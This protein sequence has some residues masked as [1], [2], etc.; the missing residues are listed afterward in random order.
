[1][2]KL[3]TSLSY[4]T[5]FVISAVISVYLVWNYTPL[6]ED[7]RTTLILKLRPYL[8]EDFLLHDFSLGLGYI[9]FH[10][11]TTSNERHT[12]QV[13]LEEIRFNYDVIQLIRHNFEPLKVLKSVTL[14][15]P[16]LVLYQSGD[17]KISVKQDGLSTDQMVQKIL[18]N[19]QKIPSIDRVLVN[20]AQVHWELRNGKQ[21]PVF[22]EMNG[23]LIHMNEGN[24]RL[25][26]VGK[27]YGSSSSS[28]T[29]DGIVD[30]SNESIEAD[31]S[32]EECS[33][34]SEFPFLRNG[35]YNFENG[36]LNGQLGLH[37]NGFY[38]DSL[39]IFGQVHVKNLSAF[40]FNQHAIAGDC[41]V[42]FESRNITFS[43]FAGK[44]EEGE[45]EFEGTLEN[46][47]NPRVHWLV[48]VNNFPVKYLKQSHN[49]FEYA[50]GGILTGHGEFHGPLD[51]IRVVASVSS[52]EIMY[53]VV[54]FKNLEAGLS[55]HK[56]VLHFS[57]IRADFKKFSTEGS[58]EV[59][60]KTDNLKFL[61]KS[62]LDVPAETF[63]VVDKLNSTKI[64]INSHLAGPFLTKRFYGTFDYFFRKGDS[65]L[66][67]GRGPFT[68]DDQ[69]LNFM[70][71][72]TNLPDPV[73]ISGS[74][75][76]IFSNPTVKILKANDL[77]IVEFTSNRVVANLAKK[78]IVN[79]VMKGPYD[80]LFGSVTVQNLNG[81]NNLFS[82]SGNIKE[83]F[84]DIQNFKG[85]FSALTAP[86]T[87]NGDIELSE[88][89]L[90]LDVK[91]NS[92][93]LATGNLF[94]GY[95][96][97][98]PIKGKLNFNRFSVSD[99]V[100][101]TEEISRSL[102]QGYM[103]G[104]L[105]ISGTIPQPTVDFYLSAD[106][107][108]INNVG[109]YST[110][111]SGKLKE[112]KL[113]FENF[114]VQLNNSPVFNAN[115]W[116]D[117]RADSLY[118]TIDGDNIESNFIAE[119]IFKD[120]DVIRGHFS[121]SL[122][123]SGPS[124]RPVISG[125]MEIRDGMLDKNSFEILSAAFQDSIPPETNLTD[126]DEHIIKI[127]NFVYVDKKNYSVSAEGLVGIGENSALDL[128]INLDGNILAELPRIQP[129]F[130]NPQSSG[131]LTLRVQGS[132][133][134]PIISYADLNVY[135]GSLEFESVLPPLRN[136]KADIELSEDGKYVHI[137]GIE[138][139]LDNRW[140]KIYNLERVNV[141]S[142]QLNS[143][144][145]EDQ[146]LDF[147]TLV[148]E[149][150]ERGIPLSIP[151]LMEEGDIGYFAVDGRQKGE[152][153]YFSGPVD[154]PFARGKV[155]LYNCRVTFPFIGMDEESGEYN[156]VVEFLMNIDWDVLALSGSGNRYFVEIPAYVGEAYLDL[157]ID[158]LSDGL[159][160]SGKL[161]DES[162]RV[163]GSVES[164]RGR[165]EYLDVNFRVEKFGTEFSRFE[166]YPTVYGRAYTTVRDS[167]GGFPRDIYLTLYA[168]D[169][170][171]NQEISR[172]R[173]EDFRFKLVSSD[174]VEGE[175][176]EQ[177]LAYLGY[178][179]QN[180]PGKASEVGL[181]MTENF[182]IRPFFRPLE[183]QIER[184]LRLDY[185][186]LRS[187]V[188][189]NLFYMSTQQQYNSLN[190]PY[191]INYNVNSNMNPA[192]LLFQ[193]A[194]ITLGKYLA[195]DLYFTYTG[196]LLSGYEEANIDNAR[197]GLYHR[198]GLEY[199]LL[200][201]LLLEVEYDNFQLNTYYYDKSYLN[202]FRIR[203][204]HSINF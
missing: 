179:I 49:V 130:R 33:L 92:P 138:G 95:A 7:I 25:E 140:A 86:L 37:S 203:L 94:I 81:N 197:L 192:L 20:N 150:D 84:T 196:Q 40:I 188:T 57:H 155:V 43:R 165:V 16:K 181:T 132:R 144:F 63:S 118:A 145:F 117:L 133:V 9:A 8:G 101:N 14:K 10:G 96:E 91:I 116:W 193:S 71:E 161:N 5:I 127:H 80:S 24:I 75:E 149:T 22:D 151:G 72:S 187:R 26:L 134:N 39:Q 2:K 175:T 126:I 120:R 56:N 54:P 29:L 122:T 74:I 108:I 107:F 67:K 137:K 123:A 61:L 21:L 139:T 97:Q 153:F 152:M 48:D 157:G 12:Y 109:Y 102:Q 35:I 178:S 15:N 147:G 85:N 78:H 129:F 159:E 177:V 136:L 1:M 190:S 88:S 160:F 106:E 32:L 34:T 135:E 194:E 31:L 44:L 51:S 111:L 162:F 62:E 171:T 89:N 180:L 28:I 142:T 176:Q 163:E 50:V 169:S 125:K 110:K 11:V 98:A 173:W 65:L 166:L 53:A 73:Q 121:Y 3:R 68:L 69:F 19:F 128:S 52:P 99:Y 103:Q 164:S 36:L 27:F 17:R 42:I 64:I 93:G 58:G 47:F 189:S 30:L 59:N 199:R 131:H 46:I 76:Q 114:W 82:L 77:P 124:K 191:P 100:A 204:R 105:I 184:G 198:L 112:N 38:L 182:L 168:I 202:D 167:I 154:Q 200:R 146:E 18:A 115:L 83:I 170:E 141:G 172:G 13:N 55:F 79:L 186:R 113:S 4:F 6:K 201:N 45:F 66:I 148:L 23:Y 183:R 90:G 41:N 185:V 119:T 143:W 158:N 70:V 156:A 195:R 174:P 60:F 104:E 87:L